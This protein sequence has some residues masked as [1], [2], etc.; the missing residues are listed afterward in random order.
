MS[1]STSSI[2]LPPT[3]KALLDIIK[4][5]AGP[6]GL[7]DSRQA[8]WIALGAYAATEAGGQMVNGDILP[9][10]AYGLLS[11]ALLAA[12]TFGAL[13]FVGARERFQQTLVA[14]TA[15]GALIGLISVVLSL[16]VSQ[17][18]PAPLPTGKLVGFVLFP[19]VMWKF[20]VFLWLLRHASLRFI[21]AFAISAIYVGFTLLILSPLLT[22]IFNLL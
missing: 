22:R 12:T 10:L 6:A 18:F 19:L 21:P 8:L 3:P 7:P 14:L 9:S 4:L 15:T 20:T 17:I 11:A 1:F 2:S 5:E 13:I 16:A